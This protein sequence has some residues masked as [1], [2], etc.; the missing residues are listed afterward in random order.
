MMRKS[1][2]HTK[3]DDDDSEDDEEV[4]AD[5]KNSSQ[6]AKRPAAAKSS[7]K[8]P[9]AKRQKNKDAEEV[10]VVSFQLF[11]MYNATTSLRL[12]DINYYCF[13]IFAYATWPG[14][15]GK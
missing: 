11:E 2:C 3:K 1:R 9:A 6:G 10:W 5:L 13:L 12:H 7:L 8:K 4:P 14:A 15:V